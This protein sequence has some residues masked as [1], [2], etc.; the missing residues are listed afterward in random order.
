MR[1]LN[2]ILT[3]KNSS[4]VSYVLLKL[5]LAQYQVQNYQTRK[6]FPWSN[7]F[8]FP[9]LIINPVVTALQNQIR[10]TYMIPFPSNPS[11]A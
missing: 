1:F 3:L 4:S 6:H 9:S 10:R 2:I 5:L 8:L 11:K 7:A